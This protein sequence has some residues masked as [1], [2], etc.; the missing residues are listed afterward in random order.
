MNRS[1]IGFM[2][3]VIG[4]LD[5]FTL[6]LVLLLEYYFRRQ[7]ISPE[8]FTNY[9]IFWLFLN[10]SWIIIGWINAVYNERYIVSFEL[11]TR[12]TMET[13]LFW[14]C[15]AM[16]YL[17]F[18]RQIKLSRFFIIAIVTGFA[19]C[20]MLN[21]FTYLVIMNY[22]RS[23]GHLVKK[24]IILGYNDLAKKL[25]GYL[26]EDGINAQIVGFCEEAENVHE[27]SNYP[28]LGNIDDAL[29]MS[30]NM[31][32]NE[33][34]IYSTVAPE[35]NPRI[36]DLMKQADLECIRFRFIPDLSYF[37]KIP[38]H[39]D[40]MKDMP[41]LSLRSEPLDDVSTRARK[42]VFDI[43]VSSLVTIFILSWLVP[44]MSI[45]IWLESKG[46][47][48]FVQERTGKNNKPFRCLKFRSMKMNSDANLK[49]ATRNDDR[50]TKIGKFMRRT[51]IDEFPQFINVLKG[52]MSIVGPR[53]HMVRH[54]QD[55]SKI[56]GTY[57]VRQ[58]LK[59]GI[60]GWAQVNGYRGEIKELRHIEKRVEYDI[61][62]LEHWNLWLDIRIMFLTVYNTFAGDENAF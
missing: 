40:Y 36:Y 23:R 32:A 22:F 59:P 51:N 16:I 44:L 39:I 13:Y 49:Q 45:L 27:L 26:E 57:M 46:P 12:K 42:R 1:L 18:F 38:V 56:V 28:I 11:F 6:N 41:V 30:K 19:L 31:N 34:E 14:L 20:L 37:I 61:W 24:I 10:I 50:L 58:F 33:V 29:E 35:Q 55:Y 21:R 15:V 8:I 3:M 5:L 4:G 60:T 2:Q 53:P 25:A 17:F 43:I 48:F 62:Y 7:Y 47:V 52:E 9:L 54:T